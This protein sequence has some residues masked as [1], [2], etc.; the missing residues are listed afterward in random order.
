MRM[1]NYLS[2]LLMEDEMMV[3]CVCGCVVLVL[4][5]VVLLVMEIF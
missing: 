2:V 4:G 1:L 5:V 3:C